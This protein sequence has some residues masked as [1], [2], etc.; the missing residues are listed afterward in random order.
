MMLQHVLRSSSRRLVAPASF[1]TSAAHHDVRN[2]VNTLIIGGG[3]IG[4]ST[5]YH[6]AA[7]RHGDGRGIVVVEKDPSYA[8]A[9]ATLSAGGIRMQFSL[10]ENIQMSLYGR[11]FL[12]NANQLLHT[13]TSATEE[14]DIQFQEHGYLFLASTEKGR[15]QMIKNIMVQRKAGC[16][17]I[18]LLS[19]GELKIAFPW[20][21]SD[22][23]LMGSYGSKGEGWFDPSSLIN[24][25]KS[26][27]LEMGVMYVHGF[28]V[29]AKRDATGRVLSVD[30]K[31]L[32]NKKNGGNTNIVTYNVDYVVNA[33]GAKCESLM[34]LL[35]GPEK[36]Q[37]LYPLPVKPRKRC[38]FFFHCSASDGVPHIAPLT[39]D[40]ESLVYFRSEGS[41]GNANFLCGVSPKGNADVDCYD[42]KSFDFVDYNLFDDIIWPAL[43]HRVPAFGEIKV[44]NS[45]AGLYEY[46]I[47]DQVSLLVSQLILIVT[48]IITR[49]QLTK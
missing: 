17:D 30:T 21:Y 43:Y 26:K 9:S 18:K 12:R 49:S 29:G 46:N 11:D 20:L 34:S 15:E 19:R 10:K 39:I 38:I 2:I 33:A 27:I 28:P 24:G 31:I 7:S 23:I 35:A 41:G 6:L 37:L 25:L 42:E 4:L 16:G 3:P 47:I 1:S 48:C 13:S 45:W 44:K 14:I 8:H 22:D 40:P 5:A 36:K 32:G